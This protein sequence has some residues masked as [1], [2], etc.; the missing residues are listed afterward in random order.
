M[1]LKEIP[2]A[3]WHNHSDKS[4]HENKDSIIRVEEMI[5]LA[6]EM[7]HTGVGLTDHGVLSNHVKAIKYLEKLKK[8]VNKKLEKEPFNVLL[9]QRKEQLDNFK[10]GLGTEIYLVNKEE[11]DYAR[12]NNESTKFYHLVLLAKNREGHKALRKISTRAWENNFH[13]RSV[14]RLPTYKE[15]LK[16]LINECKNN[17]VATSACLGSEFA[18]LVLQYHYYPSEENKKKIDNFLRYMYDLF[19][20]DFY[21]EIQPSDGEEQIIYNKLALEI[22]IAYGI[23]AIVATDAHYHTKDKRFAH[24]IYLKSQNAEREVDAFYGYTYMMTVEEIRELMPYLDDNTFTWIID[25]TQEIAWKIENYDLAKGTQVPKSK[26][27]FDFGFISQLASIVAKEPKYTYIQKYLTSNHSVDR[28]L[29]QQIEKGVN[30]KDIKWTPEVLERIDRELGSL[31]EISIKLDQRLSS[32]YVLTQFIVEL[33]WRTSLVG[34]SRG[35]AG[36][37]FIAYCLDIVQINGMNVKG[38]DME[39]P[40]WRHISA[41]RPELPDVD[42]DTQAS[43]RANILEIIKQEF[44]HKNVLNICTFKTE[45]TASAIQSVCRGM[46]I[47]VDDAKYLSSLVIKEGNNVLTV[48]EC[49]ELYDTDK[50]IRKFIDEL[51]KFDEIEEYAGFIETILTIEGLCCGKSV[52][53]SGL[54]I[55]NEE[56]YEINAMMQSN[57]GQPTTQ[58]DMGDSD[59]MGGLKIDALTIEGLDRIRKTLD[60]L[61]KAGKIEWQGTLKDT[62]N[63]YLHPDVLEYNNKEMWEVL[64]SGEVINAFQFE[65][66]VG[67]SALQ[68]IQPHNLQEVITGNSL[69]RLSVKEGEQ[70]I[71]KFVRYKHNIQMAYEEMEKA[72]L[73]MKEIQI[74]KD[75]LEK[76]Y[77]V[78]STQ[79]DVMRMSMD[80]RISNFGLLDANHLRKSIAKSKAKDMIKDVEEK[81]IESGIKQGNR[82]EL[83]EFVWVNHIEPMLGYAF[84]E[85]HVAG[86]S[87][88]LLQELN[89]VWKYGSLFWKVACLSVN[90]GDISEDINK[91]A[92]Y[93]AIAKAIGGME[94][95]FVLPPYINKAQMEFIPLEKEQK[96]MYSLTA[97]VG[98]GED[99]AREIINNRP[100]YSFKS[101]YE[102]MVVTKKVPQAKVY[103]LIKAGCFDKLNKDRVATMVEFINLN[104]E[105]KTSLSVA[106]IPKLMEFNLVPQEFSK[107]IMLYNF[108]K[109]VFNKKNISIQI[110]KSRACYKI[111][112]DA[113]EYYYNNYDTIFESTVTINDNG[114][115]C[116]DNKAFD[117]I[118]ENEIANFKNWLNTQDAIDRFNNKTKSEIWEKYCKGNIPSWEMS[119]ICYYTDAHELDYYPI[120]NYYKIDNFFELD[121]E[122]VVNYTYINKKGRECKIHKLNVIAGTV[123][124]K[125][126]NKGLIVVN[127]RY[128]VVEVKLGKGR[129]SHYDRSVEDDKS[130]LTRGTKVMIVGIRAGEVFYP[131]TYSQSVYSHTMMKIDVNK[132]GQ[133]IIR[134]DRSFAN[135]DME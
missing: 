111:P 102:K 65:T 130:W 88:I 61:I 46:N 57:S 77:F 72:G 40:D 17:V 43:E 131:K 13:F 135:K 26:T 50:E 99:V 24:S 85:P 49:L 105:V 76:Q 31:W 82:R 67:K 95:G 109:Y 79:E 86:Y 6:L 45:G 52:H 38:A 128:G 20:D 23:K 4:N 91:G 129:F 87:L 7:G 100:Y 133:M 56:Y 81:F 83:L 60:L 92:D 125:N 106:N 93:G 48:R 15:D 107:E 115:T 89:L 120:E 108:R 21:I 132:E 63:K 33:M 12:E 54:Y 73:N 101:F 94:K 104:T 51:R 64:Y 75:H 32:Y 25:N 29:I 5:D 70:P 110:N 39:L 71:D 37:F 114:D 90:A 19:E 28:I 69:M 116:L 122:P 117:K 112:A 96:A 18:N 44:G 124:D 98:I 123:V 41:E 42:L 78:A 22:A 121:K 118:Y 80:E 3:G 1:N 16:E 113:L 30:K 58:F 59:Y 35:S 8:D 126:K 53:A 47:S 11:I 66:L 103:N 14:R 36:A 2:Y 62:Y 34:V 27:Q 55:F 84:S 10:L 74:M 127:T 9:L 68:K 134:S 119:S 97:I